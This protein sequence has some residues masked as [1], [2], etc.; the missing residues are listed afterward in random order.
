MLVSYMPPTVPTPTKQSTFPLLSQ[1]ASP[2]F[3]L[4]V[5]QCTFHPPITGWLVIPRAGW[6]T[7]LFFAYISYVCYNMTRVMNP[8]RG[9]VIE[10]GAPTLLPLWREGTKVSGRFVVERVFI[11]RSWR[12]WAGGQVDAQ[13]GVVRMRPTVLALS[14]PT[15]HTVAIITVY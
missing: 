9:I 14:E 7:A 2:N 15:S 11:I 6:Q 4:R 3:P 1:K 5:S 8:M 12:R 10:P 13:S